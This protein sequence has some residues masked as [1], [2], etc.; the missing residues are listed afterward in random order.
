MRYRAFISYSHRDR[1]WA[2]WL[3][4]VL[5]TYRV[6][7]HLFGQS[8]TQG[9]IPHRLA[10]VFRDREELASA[11]DLNERV[12]QALAESENLIVICSP[13]AARSRWVNE[14]VLVYKR[15]GHADRVFCL[16]VDG[17]PGASEQPGR[18]TEEC[19]VPALRHALDEHGQLADRRIEPVAAD[20][21]PHGD[22]K[23]NAKL[24]LIA[25]LLGVGFDALRQ[26][27]QQRRQRRLLAITTASLVGMLLTGALAVTAWLARQDAE[28]RRE[29]AEDLIGFMLGDLTRNLRSI[30]RLDVFDAIGDKALDYFAALREQDLTERTIAQRADALTLIGETAIDRADLEDAVRAF[31][32]SVEQARKLAQRE[33]DHP[34]WQRQLAD[35]EL[36]LGYAY[37]QQGELDQALD[38]FSRSLAAAERA[39]ALRPGDPSL[40]RTQANAHNN[41]AHVRERR[42][43]LDDARKEYETVLELQ[44]RILQAR[45]DD[46]DLK[47]ELGFA[48]NNLGKVLLQL[49]EL[50]ATHRYYERDLEIKRALLAAEPAHRLWQRYLAISENHMGRL[51]ELLGDTTGAVQH[52]EAA[53]ALSEQLVEEDPDNAPRL[54]FL[55][56]VLAE[57]GRLARMAGDF[58]LASARQRRAVEMLESLVAREP[59]NVDFRSSLAEAQ[60]ALADTLASS[61]ATKDAVILARIA[62]STLSELAEL[63]TADRV[64][65]LELARAELIL[66]RILERSGESASARATYL[67]ARERL[68]SFAADAVDPEVL[69]ARAVLLIAL[70]EQEAARRIVERLLA[71][72][73]RQP[74]FIALI[75]QHELLPAG[76]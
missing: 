70:G 63:D 25:G 71:S 23:T 54:R 55:A 20:A 57:N 40:L 59:A 39:L 68:E 53:L 76:L 75:R 72:G 62:L 28:R 61:D 18:E 47:A 32:E 69:D 3:H 27:E 44:H 45:P 33:P 41:I 46:P 52:V 50:A 35:S 13:H 9:P 8:G 17:E 21:R 34:D 4:R 14:E 48:Y 12:Q 10:P 1:R 38:N 60:L 67:D 66:A 37:W 6:P 64:A 7:R 42:G 5:E 22:G 31:R 26:R 11:A 24:K 65:H 15:L 19:F 2:D 51:L 43:E 30:G 56:S 58:T 73:Y 74:D 49:G 36:W 29:Q 16:I